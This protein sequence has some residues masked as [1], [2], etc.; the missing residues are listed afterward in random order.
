MREG[1]INLWEEVE[2]DEKIKPQTQKERKTEESN[3]I[4]INSERERCWRWTR[5][6]FQEGYLTYKQVRIREKSDWKQYFPLLRYTYLFR[7]FL[8]L[9]GWGKFK[10]L[11]NGKMLPPLDWHLNYLLYKQETLLSV[12]VRQKI[13]SLKALGFDPI[14]TEKVKNVSSFQIPS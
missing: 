1:G 9:W 8:I 12:S 5:N 2:E 4:Q 10:C 7:V 11:H 3:E 13:Q 14:N 6:H